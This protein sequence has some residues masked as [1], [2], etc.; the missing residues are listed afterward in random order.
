MATFIC[1]SIINRRG[2]KELKSLKAFID[3]S[4]TV[5]DVYEDDNDVSLSMRGSIHEW[6]HRLQM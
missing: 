4:Q 3:H 6:D 5:D 1:T 2:I